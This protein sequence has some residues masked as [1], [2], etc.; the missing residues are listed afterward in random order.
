MRLIPLAVTAAL[1][2]GLY[3][4]TAA[5]HTAADAE[6]FHGLAAGAIGSI[7]YRVGAWEG[8]DMSVPPAARTLLR[9]NALMSR[10]Y[11]DHTSG[12]QANLVI[13]QCKDCRDMSGHYPP[14]CYPAHGWNASGPPEEVE[15][16]VGEMRLPVRRYEY[17]QAGFDRQNG[18]VIYGLF[19][20]PGRGLATEM[21][22]VV[23]A[24][25]DYRTRALGAA[26]VQVL[27][28]PGL[29]RAEERAIFTTLVEP[30]IPAIRLL[31]S[32]PRA[33]P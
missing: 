13:V 30:A 6:P 12:R 25:A 27:L 29:S 26:Q 18:L 9:P 11:V 3:V 4:E 28:A 31:Q 24:A 32:Q 21:E 16:V 14:V 20:L 7:P 33:H 1:L 22:A 10:T 15:L 8:T 19:V 17:R 2:V 23:E 5:H